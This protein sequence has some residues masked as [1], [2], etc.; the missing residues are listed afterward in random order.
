MAA[1]ASR[2]IPKMATL[3]SSWSLNYKRNS[4][5]S[6]FLHFATAQLV[7]KK[8]TLKLMDLTFYYPELA[9]WACADPTSV[10]RDQYGPVYVQASD[11]CCCGIDKTDSRMVPPAGLK[12][13]TCWICRSGVYKS[14]RDDDAGSGDGLGVSTTD[15]F[16]E[17]ALIQVI[18]TESGTSQMCLSL[19]FW[20]TNR[21][22]P[23]RAENPSLAFWKSWTVIGRRSWWR[24]VCRWLINY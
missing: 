23:T 10:T 16:T 21:T 18:S 13:H 12:L 22:V 9:R 15:R 20:N 8:L 7:E 3:I 14:H 1:H 17:C 19:S 4:S 2:I 5:T 24:F 6:N 11:F